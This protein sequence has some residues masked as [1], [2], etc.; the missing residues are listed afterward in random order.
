MNSLRKAKGQLLIFIDDLDRL[1]KREII[2]VLR[3]IRNTA[4]FN[5][6]VYVVSYDKDY[7]LEAI[8]SFNEHNYKSFVEKIFQFEFALPAYEEALNRETI[9][10][11][12]KENL[13]E[14]FHK[15]ID[16]VVD[17][18]PINGLSLTNEIIKTQRDVVRF[19]N[20]FLFEIDPIKEEIFL[21]DF[22]LLQL[23]KLKYSKVFD[24]LVDNRYK[25]FISDHSH[26]AS[27]YYRFRKRSEV[28][29]DVDFIVKFMNNT[30]NRNSK[31]EDE[32]IEFDNFLEE[33]KD[34]YG[35]TNYDRS[36]L[37]KIVVVLLRNKSINDY[38]FN[39]P[40]KDIER[41]KAANKG[42]YN[43]R[44]F[45]KYFSFRLYEGD[46]SDYEFEN[47]RLRPF[48]EYRNQVISWINTGKYSE[49]KDKLAKI[50]DFS[51]VGEFEN[52]INILFDLGREEIKKYHPHLFDYSLILKA[53]QFP[54]ERSIEGNI[55]SKLYDSLEKYRTFLLSIFDEAPFPRVFEANVVYRLIVT[56]FDFVLNSNE[57]EKLSFN[58]FE[59]FIEKTTTLDSDFWNLYNCCKV[60]MPNN[61]DEEGGYIPEAVRLAKSEFRKRISECD[62]GRFIKQT[63]PRSAYY[64]LQNEEWSFAFNSL[65][66]FEEWFNGTDNIDR[67]TTCFKE[68]NDFY[69]KIKANKYNPIIFDFKTLK[70]IRWI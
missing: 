42:F 67:E 8:K 16:W 37:R 27:S 65:E 6:V 47:Y 7:I 46:L 26:E 68:F 24:S 52:H 62:L 28:F 9:K 57:L 10:G 70:P 40:Q 69:D 12:L 31:E 34:I 45:H 29:K 13:H 23:I 48:A 66:C 20:S 22:Y 51:E 30:K 18:R 21:Y 15:Q 54:V 61:N 4:N 43:P 39:R 1:D 17:D 63:D 50:E 49:L 58:F 53:L 3:I 64:K 59:T 60:K 33:K 38:T 56:D 25:F 35:L 2:E 41:D 36:L 5:N 55:I 11:L 44:N 14:K 19:V 32:E